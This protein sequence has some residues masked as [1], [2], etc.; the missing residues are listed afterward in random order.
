[1]HPGDKAKEAKER[2]DREAE[3]QAHAASSYVTPDPN[4]MGHEDE[5]SGLP[6][7]SLNLRHV[8]STGRAREEEPRR[9]SR[10]DDDK[11]HYDGRSYYDEGGY[12]EAPAQHGYTEG[13]AYYEPDPTYYDPEDQGY[14]EQTYYDYRSGSGSGRGSST[15]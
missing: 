4:E 11:S 10:V 15:T 7:G 5:L 2:Q 13:D 6:W 8:V 3:N 14:E 9:G 12:Y 1:M